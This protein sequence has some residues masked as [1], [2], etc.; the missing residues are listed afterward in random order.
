MTGVQL[1]I[2][3]F[4]SD[5]EFKSFADELRR[6][7]RYFWKTYNYGVT[8]ATASDPGSIFGR[9]YSSNSRSQN[10]LDVR[11]PVTMRTTPTTVN[12]YAP[13]SGTI[14]KVSTGSGNAPACGTEKTFTQPQML[15]ESGFSSIQTEDIPAED[16][17]GAHFTCD[18]EL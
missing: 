14:S 2:G 1:E 13:H 4:S 5:F 17:V 8:P 11:F 18:A 12:A 7:Q 16:F 3:S 15:G 9:N 6:C 10:S